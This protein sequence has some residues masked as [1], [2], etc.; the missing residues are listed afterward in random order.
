MNVKEIKGKTRYCVIIRNKADDKIIDLHNFNSDLDEKG[1]ADLVA[2]HKS[3]IKNSKYYELVKDDQLK[4]M[5]LVSCKWKNKYSI[6]DIQS[7]FEDV[8]R[9]LR[10]CNDELGHIKSLLDDFKKESKHE[11]L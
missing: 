5:I 7:S 2:N 8:D 4:E 1:I 10:D 6:D 9:Y 3:N 11:N